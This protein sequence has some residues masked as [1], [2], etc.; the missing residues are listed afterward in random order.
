MNAELELMN[1]IRML[2]VSIQMVLTI[3]NVTLVMKEMENLALTSMS[4]PLVVTIVPRHRDVEI[5]PAALFASVE[6]VSV[7]TESLVR[8]STSVNLD[9]I[10]ALVL[11]VNVSILSSLSNVNAKK[12]I[13]VM[14]VP[15][16]ISM[17]AAKVQMTAHR[18]QIVLIP[19]AV[20]SVSAVKVIRAMVKTALILMI[21][22][23]EPTVVLPMQNV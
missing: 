20:I 2:V 19:W 18:T 8:I 11:V 14:G 23:S 16:S 5:F 10:I 22:K 17:S 4:V 1:A 15:V 9:F 12:A 3:V 7:V 21:A 6:E 13:V